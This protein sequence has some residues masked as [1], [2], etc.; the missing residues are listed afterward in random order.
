[1]T[2]RFARAYEP[3]VVDGVHL[4]SRDDDDRDLN[5]MR[6]MVEGVEWSLRSKIA[7]LFCDTRAGAC[8]SAVLK[9]CDEETAI[10]ITDQMEAACRRWQGGHNGISVSGN[11]GAD[12]SRGPHWGGEYQLNVSR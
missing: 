11:L 12:C 3:E 10:R 1:M 2:A 9:L 8:Y 5:A 4:T 6:M 7:S